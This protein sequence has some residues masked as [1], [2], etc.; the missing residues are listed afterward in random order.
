MIDAGLVLA[1]VALGHAGFQLTVTVVVYPALAA[2]PQTSWSVSHDG[3]SRRI[4]LLVVPWY[5]AL[6]ASSGWALVAADR[7]PS[8]LVAVAA[9]VAVVVVTGVAAAP[10]HG[11]LGREGPQGVLLRRL[12]LVDRL[13]LALALVGAVAAVAAHG[14][15]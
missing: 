11:R 2:V 8:L 7:S 15:G 1:L 13:R 6:L 5:A 14:V 9:L 3:H 4:S 10:L 12:L